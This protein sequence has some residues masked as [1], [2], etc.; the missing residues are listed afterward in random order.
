MQTIWSVADL[1]C[2]TLHWWLPVI[3]FLCGVRRDR[4]MLDKIVYVADNDMPQ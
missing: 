2:N 3:L 1:L 4:S